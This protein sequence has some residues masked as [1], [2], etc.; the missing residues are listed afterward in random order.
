MSRRWPW[1]ADWVR[2]H[3]KGGKREMPAHHNL[4][5]YLAEYIEACGIASD[6][7]GLSFR[8]AIYAQVQGRTIF[9]PPDGL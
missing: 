3:E 5:T 7:K 6:K 2:L 9:C 4:D 8:T 1:T